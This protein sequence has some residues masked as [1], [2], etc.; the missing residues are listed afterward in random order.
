MT[1]AQLIP[2]RPRHA[3]LP[4]TPPAVASFS[5]VSMGDAL[6]GALVAG[7]FTLVNTGLILLD[8]HLARR[9]DRPR[10]TRRRRRRKDRR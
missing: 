8:H 1:A 10:D 6:A 9:S 2:R 4:L 3:L 7:A 5:L